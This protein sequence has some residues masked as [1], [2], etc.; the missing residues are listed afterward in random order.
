MDWLGLLALVLY[1]G[2]LVG[3]FAGR[4]WLQAW[5]Q[6][7]ATHGFDTKL[8]QLRAELRAKEEELKSDLRVKESEIT[9]LRD[10]VLSGRTQREALI[11]KRRIEAVDGLWQA[12]MALAPLVMSSALMTSIKFDA[13]AAAS[14]R[15]PKA[16]E[17]FETLSKIGGDPDEKIKK[18]GEVPAKAQQPFVSPMAWAYFSAYQS[19]ILYA[20]M[21]LRILGIGMEKPSEYF[22][23]EPIRDLLKE[24]LPDYADY[25]DQYGASAY[26]YLLPELE[27][28]LLA[29]LQKMLT[30]VEQD[31]AGV[32]HAARIMA[33]AEQ[34]RVEQ[35]EVGPA[36]PPP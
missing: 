9:A 7:W 36:T 24:T 2:T 14:A 8:E 1:L 22:K 6:R 10:G 27:K 28:R 15:N 25:I 26:H 17:L 35:R 21:R 13:A 3:V 19:I 12:Y 5:V 18:L 32:A 20:Y 29:E 4:N 31:A 23:E 34:A 33:L 30:G 11:D 16:R